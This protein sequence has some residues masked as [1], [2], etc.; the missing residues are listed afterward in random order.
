[1]STGTATPRWDLG[2]VFNE[3]FEAFKKEIP[4][5]L[6]AGALFWAVGWL[7]GYLTAGFG[8]IVTVVVYGP[9]TLGLSTAAL[10]TV[11]GQPVDFNVLFSGFQNLVPAVVAGLLIWLFTMI[12]TIACLLPGLFVSMIYMLT[13]LYMT[14]KELDYWDAMEASRKQI[15]D[16]LNEWFIM[17]LVVFGLYVLGTAFCVGMIV[18]VPLATLML[19][20]AYD[21]TENAGATPVPAE[22]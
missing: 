16:H 18:T 9:L 12:G 8:L 4:L 17:W 14:D 21:R 20:V 19:A 15:M 22:E 7:V 6:G 10:K 13:F 11:R 3:A 5:L 1:M 2:Q